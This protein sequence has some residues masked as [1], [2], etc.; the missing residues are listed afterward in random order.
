[1]TAS[2]ETMD[3]FGNKSID[4]ASVKYNTLVSAMSFIQVYNALTGYY[5]CL[6][7]ENGEVQELTFSMSGVSSLED[8]EIMN[9]WD[10]GDGSGKW[11]GHTQF[12][13]SCLGMNNP[14]LTG[15]QIQANVAT[16]VYDN[17]KD[18]LEQ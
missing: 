13:D 10:Q 7:D 14:D 5:E 4:F 6:L 17:I 2:F 18:V 3:A 16:M 11:V 9:H 15:E 12:I 8:L 1:M